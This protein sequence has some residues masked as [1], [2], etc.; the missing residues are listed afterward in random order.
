MEDQDLESMEK[1][2]LEEEE[3]EKTRL[4][5]KIHQC[6]QNSDEWFMVRSGKITGS[7]A[8]KIL[9]KGKGSKESETK[10]KYAQK[11]AYERLY[12]VPIYKDISYI[13]AV[14][15]GREYEKSAL[16]EYC[17]KFSVEQNAIGFIEIDVQL[18]FE[19]NF[20]GCSPDGLI[21]E[22]GLVEIKCPSQ[23]KH[24]TMFFDGLTD[25]EWLTQCKYNLF[26]SQRE[27]IDF[28]SYDPFQEVKKLK[29]YV[30]RFFRD[31]EWEENFV[32]HIQK[33]KLIMEEQTEKLRSI[34]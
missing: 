1:Q 21:G 7:E 28:V 14:K 31:A 17:K 22:N 4:K 29:I 5:V 27:W 3:Q 26:V 9:L 34:K 10:I 6:E 30:Q 13:S 19:Q 23:E 11:L 25:Q 12:G 2:R 16:N 15:H 33:F 24:L 8:Y 32:K 18:D 20:L